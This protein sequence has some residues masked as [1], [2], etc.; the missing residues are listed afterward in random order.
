MTESE[1]IEKIRSQICNEK[2][3]QRYCRD[4]C[5][6]GTEHCAYSMA[7]QALE[8]IQQYRAIGLTPT[9]VKDLIAS[10][11]KA[12]KAALEN[13]HL[14]DDYQAIGTVEECRTA[15]ERMKP[16]IKPAVEYYS[17]QKDGWCVCPKCIKGIGWLSKKDQNSFCRHCGAEFDWNE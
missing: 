14:L 13:A 6:H 5:I 7:I 16:R 3:V 17:L 8:E 1:T 12:H 9:M 15:M 2:G 4:N 10:E 11:K